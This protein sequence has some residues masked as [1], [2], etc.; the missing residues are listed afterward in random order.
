MGNGDANNPGNYPSVHLAYPVA[1][2]AYEWA[3]R[4]LDALDSRIQTILTLGASLTIA[5]PVALAALDINPRPIWIL[6]AMGLFLIALFTGTHARLTGELV[7]LSPKTL[8]DEWLSFDEETFKRYLVFFS[9]KHLEKNRRL[10]M[11]RH[12]L[13]VAVTLLLFLEAVCLAIA[14][15][16]PLPSSSQQT[17]DQGEKVA[18][19]VAPGWGFAPDPVSQI[20]TVHHHQSAEHHSRSLLPTCWYFQDGAPGDRVR[21][22]YVLGFSF[23]RFRHLRRDENYLPTDP[24]FSPEFR[25]PIQ[26]SDR[27]ASG[28]APDPVSQIQTVHHHQSAE[29]HFR[30]LLP[31]CLDNTTRSFRSQPSSPQS[32]GRISS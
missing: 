14:V 5:A 7:L 1:I 32:Q 3:V 15:A 22:S 10:I 17:Q 6:A 26:A 12:K 29:H 8:H 20:Q 11:K 23:P 18:T 25:D 9:G 31:A 28:L 21:R 2:E 13:L 4:R 24:P 19:E 27:A 30:S 16:Y